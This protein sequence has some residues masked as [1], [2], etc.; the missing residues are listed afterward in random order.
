MHDIVSYTFEYG[1]PQMQALYRADTQ[2]RLGITVFKEEC[3][4]T[5]QVQTKKLPL[6]GLPLGAGNII[7]LSE[8]QGLQKMY[9]LRMVQVGR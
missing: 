1:N 5:V 9:A 4:K 2:S 7:K 6:Q 3:E 8:I